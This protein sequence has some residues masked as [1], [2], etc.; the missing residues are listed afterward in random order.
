MAR[1]LSA[2]E[3]GSH[4]ILCHEELTEE[5]EKMFLVSCCMSGMHQ[6][7]IRQ[8]FPGT[9]LVTCPICH[10]LTQVT[11]QVIKRDD[12]SPEDSDKIESCFLKHHTV[13]AIPM[14]TK[15][16]EG[17][18]IALNVRGFRAMRHLSR[19]MFVVGLA[20]WFPL[21][22]EKLCNWE[23]I[24]SRLS[25]GLIWNMV[26]E[27]RHRYALRVERDGGKG[28]VFHHL[29][30]HL[31]EVGV[32]NDD[33]VKREFVVRT[34]NGSGGECQECQG[35]VSVFD[36]QRS[37]HHVALANRAYLYERVGKSLYK[38]FDQLMKKKTK[39]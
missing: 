28:D 39:K 29:L 19:R 1:T 34:C 2:F 22:K 37:T 23:D 5:G 38:Q 25:L 12:F 20:F 35:F 32:V 33:V 15:E 26:S 6:S 13:N 30:D 4:C 16:I 36:D 7:C 17:L 24:V 27:M 11:A 14:T 31:L 10:C 21:P 3:L 9:H 18:R 8:K